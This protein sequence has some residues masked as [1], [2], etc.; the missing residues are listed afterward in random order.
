MSTRKVN[1]T[2]SIETAKGIVSIELSK[3][4]VSGFNPRKTFA[5]NELQELAD[6][7]KQVGVLQPILVRP[8]GKKYEI[9]CGERRFRASVLADTQTIPAIVRELSD[10]ESLEIGITENL[11]RADVSPIEEATA[12]KR[13]ADTGRYD[14]AKLAFRFGKSEAYIRN[15]MKLND[16]SEDVLDLVNRDV[17]SI[18]VALELC[19]YDRETQAVIYEKH[20]QHNPNSLYNDWRNLTG[21]EFVKRLENNYCT[22]LSR[23]R[24]DKSSCTKCQFNTNCYSL[25][26]DEKGNGKCLNMNC[27]TERNRQFLV[28]SCKNIIAEHP[29]IDICKPVYNSGHEDV[30]A[31]LS[32]QGFTVDETSV[33]T[34]PDA[35]EPPDREEFED[36]A[37]YEEAKDEYYSEMA[38][39]QAEV[40]NIEQLFMESKAKRTV[41]FKDNAPQIGYVYLTTD[42]ETTGGKE[43]TANPVAKLEKQDRRN[44]EI[45][46]ENIVDDTRKYIRE[47][48]IPDSDF[49][50]FEDK[51][52]YFVMLEDL[53]SEHFTL[54]LEKPQNKWHLTDEDKIAIINNLTEEQKTIIR[55][56]FL[57][58]HLSDTFGVAKKSYLMLEFA[59]LHFPEALAETENRYNEVYTKRHER[60]TERL[61]ALNK[62]EIQE[63]A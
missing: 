26:P 39:Y 29:D 30:Y 41:T 34:F 57:T 8:K 36:D 48:E 27:L 46:V 43:E 10:D 40:D 4:A 23:Y 49:T 51:L 38:E 22:D 28:E 59:R 44:R 45:A 13:L 52:L 31:D 5:A 62:A 37:E 55:R 32:Q 1:S 19:K 3:I 63:V 21:K 61:E 20:L 60:I 17:L 12:Y 47:T 50:E 15:R 11:I 33:R 58:K 54:F 42:G 2:K 35:P 14:V 56:D 18:T 6:S 53:K 16:L 7:I 9:V 25:F 24:F